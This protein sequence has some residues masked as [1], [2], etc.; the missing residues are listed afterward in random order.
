MW[1]HYQQQKK[2]K[3]ECPY[4][5][6][7]YSYVII[8]ILNID[9]SLLIIIQSNVSNALISLIQQFIFPYLQVPTRHLEWN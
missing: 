2:Q 8:N 6:H 7:S 9:M 4:S 1:K 3:Y 5:L